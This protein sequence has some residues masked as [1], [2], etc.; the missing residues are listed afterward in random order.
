MWELAL[1]GYICLRSLISCLSSLFPLT[2]LTVPIPHSYPL[3][4]SLRASRPHVSSVLPQFC[5]LFLSS[6]FLNL[7]P[8]NNVL[9]AV[10]GPWALASSSFHLY[11]FTIK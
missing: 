9:D 10:P 1:G 4:P 2:F 7:Y 6:P 11:L 8:F 5:L 3:L